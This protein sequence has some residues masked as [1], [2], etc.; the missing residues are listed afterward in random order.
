MSRIS[1]GFRPASTSSSSKSFGSVASA[2]RQLQPL[3]A[4]DGQRVGRP[5]EHVGEADLA[6]D[7]LGGGKRV[8]R[9]AR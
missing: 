2:S 7:L 3:A 4:G 9:A 6:R 5:V 1:E 8:H